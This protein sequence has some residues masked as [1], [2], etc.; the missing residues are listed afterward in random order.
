MAQLPL[1]IRDRAGPIDVDV[2]RVTR[3]DSARQE[4]GGALDDPSLIE[5]IEPLDRRCST[6]SRIPSSLGSVH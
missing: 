3:G 5:S 2:D 4:R 6:P 1:H